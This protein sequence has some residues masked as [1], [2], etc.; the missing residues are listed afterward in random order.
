MSSSQQKFSEVASSISRAAINL[1]TTLAKLTVR[2]SKITEE[3]AT[4]TF[5]RPIVSVTAFQPTKRMSNNVCTLLRQQEKEAVLACEI[6]IQELRLHALQQDHTILTAESQTYGAGNTLKV[7]I[8][9]Q[10]PLLTSQPAVIQAITN[11][12]LVTV[13][14][15]VTDK[16]R[17]AVAAVVAAPVIPMDIQEQQPQ[18]A[19]I[20]TELLKRLNAMEKTLLSLQQGKGQGPHPRQRGSAATGDGKRQP[21]QKQDNRKPS[22]SSRAP[23]PARK[24]DRENNGSGQPN[25]RNRP[26]NAG[27]RKSGV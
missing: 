20:N 6:K 16:N 10:I 9:Q 24:E 18:V 13:C 17:K 25:P 5:K 15:H 2:I 19:A 26:K 22:S 8:I 1:L 21:N 4:Q 11:D 7:L 12:I 23:T 14:K 27:K 3:L